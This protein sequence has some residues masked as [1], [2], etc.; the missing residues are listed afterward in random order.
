L[1]VADLHTF[2]VGVA[3]VLVHNSSDSAQDLKE[4]AEA[5]NFAWIKNQNDVVRLVTSIPTPK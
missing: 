4:A 2:A 1:T 5:V 3:S